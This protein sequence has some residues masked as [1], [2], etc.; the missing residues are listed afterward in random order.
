MLGK[1][2][3]KLEDFNIFYIFLLT[4]NVQVV[5]SGYLWFKKNKVKLFGNLTKKKMKQKIIK[6]FYDAKSIQL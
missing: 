4:N 1:I 3:L 2:I 5:V 6:S